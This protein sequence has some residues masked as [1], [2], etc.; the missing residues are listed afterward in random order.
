MGLG[1]LRSTNEEP[2]YELGGL[3]RD[4]VFEHR[5]FADKGLLEVTLST[6]VSDITRR[7]RDQPDSWSQPG[8]LVVFGFAGREQTREAFL[9]A[10]LM[11]DRAYAPGGQAS[12]EEPA[13]AADV[14]V[15]VDCPRGS[16]CDGSPAF[17]AVYLHTV[18][19]EFDQETISVGFGVPDDGNAEGN[20]RDVISTPL[21]LDLL[22]SWLASDGATLRVGNTRWEF[23]ESFRQHLLNYMDGLPGC[24]E[25]DLQPGAAP[26]SSSG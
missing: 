20:P 8:F 6:P 1:P 15:E 9:G 22:F 17:E 10:I 21:D 25:P 18:A 2:P 13:L 12:A 5:Y 11:L 26:A 4:I 3:D 19:P 24:G 7:M 14:I 23:P 16:P